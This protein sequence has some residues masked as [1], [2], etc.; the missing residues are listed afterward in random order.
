MG[1]DEVGVLTTGEFNE[2]DSWALG[3]L[4]HG[5]LSFLFIEREDQETRG[6][7]QDAGIMYA[8]TCCF[9]E[10]RLLLFKGYGELEEPS[11]Q[12]WAVCPLYELATL[13]TGGRLHCT[14]TP[15]PDHIQSS[16]NLFI[17][18]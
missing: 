15:P 8:F 11:I 16:D 4:C 1:S 13:V 18:I 14:A 6:Q 3:C 17:G 2:L 5:C 9:L 10:K 12:R 7:E